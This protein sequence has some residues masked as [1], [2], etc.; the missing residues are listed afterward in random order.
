MLSWYLLT[1]IY[2]LNCHSL[3]LIH[4]STH[5]CLSGKEHYGLNCSTH[6]NFLFFGHDS[7]HKLGKNFVCFD[8]K[9]PKK[10]RDTNPGTLLVTVDT[11]CVPFEGLLLLCLEIYTNTKELCPQKNK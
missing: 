2:L 9:Q 8:P 10:R 11:G 3:R 1:S 4:E 5:Y 6:D 7:R